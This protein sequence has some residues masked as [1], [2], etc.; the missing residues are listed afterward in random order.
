MIGSPIKLVHDEYE[1][2]CLLS[3]KKIMIYPKLLLPKNNLKLQLIA[4]PL[5]DKLDS[6]FCQ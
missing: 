5:N 2:S 4:I 3:M 1:D 6:K